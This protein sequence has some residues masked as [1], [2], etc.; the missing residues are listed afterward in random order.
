[1]SESAQ[2]ANY[3]NT[4]QRLADSVN[5]EEPREEQITNDAANFEQQFLIG[6][7]LHAKVKATE[8]FVSLLKKSKTVKKAVGKSKD[9]IERL[10]RKGLQTAKNVAQNLQDKVAPPTTTPPP[11]P[12]PPP[13]QPPNPD[14]LEPLENAKAD[15]EA[16]R[17]ATNAAKEAAD[18]EVSNSAAD[19]AAART[20]ET[21]AKQ[22]ADKALQDSVRDNAGRITTD[23][24]NARRAALAAEQTRIAQEA[25]NAE[26][27]SE[28]SR[29][30]Q[31]A[32]QHASTAERAGED[33]RNAQQSQ[34]AAAAAR[35]ADAAARA[36]PVA[37]DADAAAAEAAREAEEAEKLARLQKGET[38]ARDIE[39]SSAVS[40]EADPIGFLVTAAAAAAT[41]LIGRKIKAHE[42]QVEGH[43]IPL[44]YTST[45]GA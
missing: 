36:G 44:S 45:I 4:V 14:D 5:Q 8:K 15:A 26:A 31:L 30:S 37:S 19:L 20:S 27:I 38:A 35:D 13:T 43:A 22:V 40:D 42:M 23:T 3:S 9:E 28:Q 41:Q 2:F 10:A 7:A 34:E 33:L 39:E 16:T 32:E 21:V 18:E 11:P 6:A 24:T 1:M 29:L 12:P 25:R 17:D